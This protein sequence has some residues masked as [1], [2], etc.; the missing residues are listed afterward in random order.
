[1]LSH[2]MQVPREVQDG[3]WV[4]VDQW[5]PSALENLCL[6]QAPMSECIHNWAKPIDSST[7]KKQT[8][9]PPYN[10]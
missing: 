6:H 7:Q 4:Q 3:P 8:I 5:D 1:M 10:L 9:K 2:L